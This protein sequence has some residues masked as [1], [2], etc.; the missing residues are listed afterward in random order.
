MLYK[1]ILYVKE[2]LTKNSK[3]LLGFKEFQRLKSQLSCKGEERKEGSHRGREDCKGRTCSSCGN[4][5][6]IVS[7]LV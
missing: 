6:I 3:L 1:K 7:L 4:F 5:T 2:K